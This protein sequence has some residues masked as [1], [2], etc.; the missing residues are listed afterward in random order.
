MIVGWRLC[1]APFAALDGEGA[2]CFGG[3][4]NRPGRPVVYF[5]DHPALAVLEVIVH[6]D[7]APDDLPDDYVLLKV[8]L[9]ERED[10]AVA[11]NGEKARDVGDA[12]LVGQR[13]PVLRVASA[14]VSQADNFLLN[15]LHPAASETRVEAS[16]P[17]RFD[18]RLLKSG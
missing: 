2:R 18:P 13:T 15:P 10:R 5:A 12:W 4:W 8:S 6:L 1:R 17:F 14:L 7:V 11:S 3:R 16:T 9:P